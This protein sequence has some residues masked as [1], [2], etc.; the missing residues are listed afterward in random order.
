M[1]SPY[2][3]QRKS[4]RQAHHGLIYA[5]DPPFNCHREACMIAAMRVVRNALLATI[6]LA[7]GVAVATGRGTRFVLATGDRK[8]VRLGRR[9]T[10]RDPGSA[11]RNRWSERATKSKSTRT[12]ATT[13]LAPPAPSRSRVLS[14]AW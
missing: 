9:R 7:L 2:L 1:P 5:L 4:S 8:R 14:N 12:P 3:P 6:S 13:S 11:D 10:R